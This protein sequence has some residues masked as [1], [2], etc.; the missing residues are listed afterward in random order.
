MTFVVHAGAKNLAWPDRRIQAY[1]GSWVASCMGQGAPNALNGVVSFLNDAQH[2]VCHT[3]FGKGE[4]GVPIKNTRLAST[5]WSCAECNE[6][7]AVLTPSCAVLKPGLDRTHHGAHC[8]VVFGQKSIDEVKIKLASLGLTLKDAPEDFDPTTL[9]G[10]D[11]ET[12][13][14]IDLDAEDSE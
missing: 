1:R 6:M 2:G 7:H 14:F 8:G 10:Y 4:D 11:A 13:D 12:G 5:V 3:G 9:E